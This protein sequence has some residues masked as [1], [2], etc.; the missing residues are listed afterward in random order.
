MKLGK[1]LRVLMKET[2][3]V[4]GSG[5]SFHN[6][7]AFVRDGTEHQDN[8]NNAFQDWLVET[9]TKPLNQAEREEASSMGKGAVRSLLS[10]E[11]G[12]LVAIACLRWDC[13]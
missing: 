5:F 8:E 12:T 1:V 2:I 4:I 6:M 10:S 11:G 13:R 7:R 9:C 3:L